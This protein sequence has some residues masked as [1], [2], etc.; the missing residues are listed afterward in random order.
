MKLLFLHGALSV[1]S[2]RTSGR[3]TNSS[4]AFA[5]VSLPVAARLPA[6]AAQEIIEHFGIDSVPNS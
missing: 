1:F 6:K 2:L 3:R 4:K 5:T